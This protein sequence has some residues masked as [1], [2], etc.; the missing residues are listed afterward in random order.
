MKVLLV[1]YSALILCM[2]CQVNRESAITLKKLIIPC[3]EI[4]VN[5]CFYF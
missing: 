5:S 3:P 2:G 1:C 4:C